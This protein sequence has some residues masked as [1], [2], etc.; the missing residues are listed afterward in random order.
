MSINTI[1]LY[2]LSEHPKDAARALEQFEPEA[3][4]EY[5]D[6]VPVNTAANIAQFMV[7]SIAVS[8]LKNMPID[9]STKIVMQLGVERGAL[10]LQRMS[11]NI[12]LD[13][14]SRMSPVFANMIRLVLRYPVGTVGQAMNPNVL[15]VQEDLT[16][17]EVLRVIK[18]SAEILHNDIYIIDHKQHLVGQVAVRQLL[19]SASD[20]KMKKMMKMSVRS[21][22]ARVNL[23]SIKNLPEWHSHESFPV[24]DHKGVFLGVLDRAALNESMNINTRDEAEPEL[25]GTALAVAELFWDACANMIIPNQTLSSRDNKNE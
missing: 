24:V 5:L 3:L 11:G 6:T 23:K 18:N 22:A 9:K 4:A 10:L 19:V 14:V 20:L 2:L 13:F 21:L 25:A 8:A 1:A 16:V 17:A 12:R 15:T 7:P